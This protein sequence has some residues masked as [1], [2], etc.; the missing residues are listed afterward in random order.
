MGALSK[1]RWGSERQVGKQS[2][3]GQLCL[4]LLPRAVDGGA[5]S[6]TAQVPGLG[7]GSAPSLFP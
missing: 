6:G 5:L 1:R 3:P 7:N 4:C 2:Q